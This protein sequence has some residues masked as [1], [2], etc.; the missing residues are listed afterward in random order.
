MPVDKR[1]HVWKLS[2][3]A[4]KNDLKKYRTALR[5]LGRFVSAARRGTDLM[6]RGDRARAEWLVDAHL[7]T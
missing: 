2:I 4:K 7:N 3:T 5:Q 6:S 1:K